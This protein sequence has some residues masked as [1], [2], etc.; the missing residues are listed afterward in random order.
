M[1]KLQLEFQHVLVRRRLRQSHLTGA[2]ANLL[3][4]CGLDR[5]AHREQRPSAG[6]ERAK[7]RIG[8]P[9]LQHRFGGSASLTENL[10]RGALPVG[11]I[12]TRPAAPAEAAIGAS[13]SLMRRKRAPCA[14]Q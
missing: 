13:E 10:G 9:L 14:R 12:G 7:F 11:R 4:L 1:R 2:A 8:E 5:D 6:N 3:E